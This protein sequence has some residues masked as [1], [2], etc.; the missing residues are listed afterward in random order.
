MCVYV[1][2]SKDRPAKRTSKQKRLWIKG[3]YKITVQHSLC[4]VKESKLRV[5]DIPGM[6]P[7]TV[8][9]AADKSLDR[10]TVRSGSAPL[11]A[12]DGGC[13]VAGLSAEKKWKGSRF[14]ASMHASVAREARVPASTATIGSKRGCIHKVLLWKRRNG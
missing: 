2:Q 8:H 3:V 5:K 4:A 7:G 10:W 13:R 14:H 9:V 6:L 11:V 12:E 1:D